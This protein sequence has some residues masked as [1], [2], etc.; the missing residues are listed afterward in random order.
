MTDADKIKDDLHALLFDVQRSI[1]Y[2]SCRQSFFERLLTLT[3]IITVLFGSATFFAVLANTGK[4]FQLIAA[5]VVT[6]FSTINLVVSPTRKSQLHD[7][8]AKR[9]I[10]LE[11]AIIG[12]EAITEQMMRSFKQKLL[13][14]ERD[15]PPIL[16]TLDSLCHNQLLKAEGYG[17]EYFVIV[18]PYQRWLCNIL[19]INAHVIRPAAKSIPMVGEQ[20]AISP[21]HEDQ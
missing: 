1:R 11:S 13:A 15:E 12:E 8:L 14:I 16:R 10:D 20:K 3:Q 4:A 18:K 21:E 6:L 2:H 19:D 5:A 17:E 9:F 7:G